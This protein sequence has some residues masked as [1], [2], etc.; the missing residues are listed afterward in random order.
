VR[1][2]EPVRTCVGCGMR[3]ARAALVRFVASEGRLALDLEARAPGR[4]AWLHR[5]PECWSAFER[6]RGPVRALRATPLPAERVR[7]GAALAV[8]VAPE[9]GR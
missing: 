1:R 5:R 7:L 3:D 8:A 2:A 4:G 6:R 9:V